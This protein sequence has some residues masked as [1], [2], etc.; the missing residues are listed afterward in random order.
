VR[1]LPPLNAVRTFE[2]AARHVSFTRAAAEL[3]VTHGAVSRQVALLEDWFGVKL[4][5]RSPSQIALTD[6]GR[7]YFREV[8]AIL[9]RLALA[10]LDLRESAAPTAL[11]INAPPTFT[12]R[13]LIGRMSA[14]Q[15]RRPEVEF[16][17][18]TS[19]GPIGQNETAFDVGIRGEQGAAAGWTAV[20]FM[21]ELIA[22][23]CHVDLANGALKTPDDL[24]AQTLVTYLTEPYDWTE[25]FAQAGATMAAGQRTLRFEQM[26]FA[27]QAVQEQIGVGLFPLFLV[28]DE[29]RAGRLC[30]PFGP[31]GLRKRAYSALFR[32]D[33]DSAPAARDFCAWLGDAGRETEQA[34]L[35]WAQS[36]GWRF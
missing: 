29:L 24:G 4:F 7:Q 1:K 12:M 32:A 25:W 20:P 6:A 11:R 19:L 17:L 8:A 23:V 3:H 22:P 30:V 35:E 15:R 21:T 2:A 10:S 13:W 31:L 16:R 27:L 36:M 34:T 33:A 14:F 18:T 26:Y 5:R 28:I 9:D